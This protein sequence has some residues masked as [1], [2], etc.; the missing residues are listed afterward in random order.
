MAPAPNDGSYFNSGLVVLRPCRVVFAHMM[1]ALS[2]TDVSTL[3]F[4]DQDFLNAYFRGQ[5]R[6]L[7]WTFNATKGLYACHRHDVW[8]LSA[9]RNI[10]FTMAKPWD[11]SSPLHKGYER[12]NQLWQAAYSEPSTL[13]RMLLR[14]HVQEKR[15]REARAAQVS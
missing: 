10:H 3:T 9:V 15:E 12:L 13:C 14:V 6:A 5:W 8:D 2:V 4:P 7:P 11:L 1:E